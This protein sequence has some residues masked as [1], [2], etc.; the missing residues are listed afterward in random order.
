MDFVHKT[1]GGQTEVPWAEKN[2]V[3]ALTIDHE[4]WDDESAIRTFYIRFF[5]VA[6]TF[7]VGTAC[8]NNGIY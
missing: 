5:V 4:M 8:V 7:A 1:K 3:V 6:M 2:L